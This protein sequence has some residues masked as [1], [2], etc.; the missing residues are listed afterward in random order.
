MT[1]PDTGNGVAVAVAPALELPAGSSLLRRLAAL[2]RPREADGA[3]VL[4][5]GD[6]RLDPDT[7]QV[8]RGRRTIELTP[9]EFKLLELFL[10]N[11]RRVLPRSLIFNMVW[12]FDFGVMSNSLNVYVGTLRRKLEAAGEPRVIHT[13]RGVGYVLRD[14]AGRH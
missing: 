6:V 11:P 3:A 10:R 4:R 9:I 2:F 7:R 13:V 12:G 5:F 1:V 14:P 8:R